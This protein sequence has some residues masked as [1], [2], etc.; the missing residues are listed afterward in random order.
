MAKHKTQTRCRAEQERMAQLAAYG[1]IQLLGAGG[2]RL[3]TLLQLLAQSG[4]AFP[5]RLWLA[6]VASS[7]G[8]T[9]RVHKGS[10]EWGPGASA[11]LVVVVARDVLKRKSC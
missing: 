2:Y 11:E 8:G 10:P 5:D 3:M 9:K 4:D 1:Q 7:E 6:E